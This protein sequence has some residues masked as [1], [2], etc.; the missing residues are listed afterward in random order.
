VIVPEGNM[1]D[2]MTFYHRSLFSPAQSTLLNAIANNNLSTME[3]L[4]IA[5]VKST[6]Q[7]PSPPPSATSTK[8]G[9]TSSRPKTK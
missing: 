6:Y 1:Q 8:N 9:K 4:T 5:N 7:N 2:M 3:G